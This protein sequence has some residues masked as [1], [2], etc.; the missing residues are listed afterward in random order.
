MY[1]KVIYIKSET[2]NIKIQD[3]RLTSSTDLHASNAVKRTKHNYMKGKENPTTNLC[4]KYY[5]F[6]TEFLFQLPHKSC[7]D[8]LV[9]SELGDRYKDHDSLLSLNI[10]FLKNDRIK[11]LNEI[12][13]L[14]CKSRKDP[15]NFRNHSQR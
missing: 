8:F 12:I 6:S 10:N 2:R 7:L 1:S 3:F 5:M 15:S 13:F 14:E 4:N 9:G 11:L